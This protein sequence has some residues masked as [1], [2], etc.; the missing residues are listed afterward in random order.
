MAKLR[1]SD[2]FKKDLK[3]LVYLL[4]FGGVTYLSKRFLVD[5]DLSIVFGGVA[6]YLLYRAE[7]ELKNEGY[8]KV[9]KG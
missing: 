6:N 8:V 9:L 3:L 7:K 4:V 5:N 2:V 1:V